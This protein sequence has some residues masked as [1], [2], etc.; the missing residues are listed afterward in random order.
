MLAIL[1]SEYQTNSVVHIYCVITS[2]LQGSEVL[3]G[4]YLLLLQDTMFCK[5][6]L[7]EFAT[8]MN[9][10]MP[11]YNTIKAEGLLPVFMSS[12]VFN[13]VSYTG[14]NGKNKKEAEQLAARAVILSLVGMHVI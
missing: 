5:S 6:I 11:T 3:S 4:S 10:E 9:L 2:A 8:K 13:G 12:L 14:G 7:N 1:K